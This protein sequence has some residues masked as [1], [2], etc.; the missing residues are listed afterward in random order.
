M[1]SLER[2]CA[3]L[4]D[5]GVNYAIVGGYAVAL[6]GAVRGTIDVDLVLRWT[7]QTL[8]AA[9]AALNGIGLVSR[10]PIGAEDVF[11][12]RDEYIENRSLIAWNFHNPNDPLEQVDV[13]I[14]YDLTGRRT[15]RFELPSG[16]I[17]VLS[18]ADLIVMKRESGRPQDLEDVRALER[19]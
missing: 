6:H 8:M 12:F 11:A 4:R 14:N 3:A 10:L 18:L 7:R 16:P 13:V 1:T 9:E 19:L 15:K 5:A 2:I 17:E